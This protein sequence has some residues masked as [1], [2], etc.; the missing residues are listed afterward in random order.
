MQVTS[1]KSKL[2]N[3][4]TAA[5]PGLY[6][7][8]PDGWSV[9]RLQALLK[10]ILRSGIAMLQYRDKTATAGERLAKALTLVS[11][12]RSYRTP[13]IINDDVPLARLVQAAG[14]HLG[15][16]DYD[17][18]LAREQLGADAIIGCSCYNDLARAARMQAMGADYLAF[19]SMFP[20]ATKPA[21]VRCDLQL[22]QQARAFGLP[23]VA[24][25]GINQD[26]AAQVMQAGADLLAVI[27]DVFDAANPLQQ[28]QDYRHLLH[29]FSHH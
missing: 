28:V 14:V 9:G 20:S 17:V 6:L 27:S 22:L 16:D 15:R 10:P 4:L 19:G 26:N 8:T 18:R 11:L 3:R 23:V 12:C 2:A 7:I 21:A 5:V 29:E 25:G 24:I 13:L 1:N